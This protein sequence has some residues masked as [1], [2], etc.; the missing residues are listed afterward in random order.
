MSRGSGVERIYQCDLELLDFVARLGFVS[1]TALS[2]RT[3]ASRSE[4]REREGRLR[5]AGLIEVHDGEWDG[6]TLHSCTAAGLR[7]CGR[8]RL[9]LPD[10]VLAEQLSAVAE[11][12]AA[13]ERLGRRIVSAREI[14]AMQESGEGEALCASLGDGALRR[15]D[16]VRLGRD[17]LPNAVEVELE[18]RSPA[19]LDQLMPAW[20][21]AVAERRFASVSWRCSSAALAGCRAAARR[22]EAEAFVAVGELW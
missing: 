15:P 11:I 13:E 14:A 20:R 4:V 9:S 3:G 22:T 21:A 18:P 5:D 6:D 10:G 19:R 1:R 2:K 7:A 12:A 17:G 16:M 8:D